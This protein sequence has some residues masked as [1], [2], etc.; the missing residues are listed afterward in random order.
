M[1]HVSVSAITDS[2]RVVV[3][4]FSRGDKL[5]VAPQLGRLTEND[6]LARALWFDRHGF[7]E[8]AEQF[9]DDWARRN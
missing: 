5:I 6:V 8:K 1:P 3:R 7:R 9:L 4:D 2:T